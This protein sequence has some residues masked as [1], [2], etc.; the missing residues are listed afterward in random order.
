MAQQTYSSQGNQHQSSSQQYNGPNNLD[1]RNISYLSQGS[2]IPHFSQSP[3]PTFQGPQALAPAP[4]PAPV[5]TANNTFATNG[6]YEMPS[7][8]PSYEGV[9]P[10]KQQPSPSPYG[11]GMQTMMTSPSPATGGYN[12]YGQQP[13][14]GGQPAPIQPTSSS[15]ASGFAPMGGSG[16]NFTGYDLPDPST[17]QHSAPAPGMQPVAD[18][19]A[20]PF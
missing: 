7:P 14:G 10:P 1:S 13:Y 3:Q 4:A 19:Y 15:G 11:Q 12:N 20:S 16:E 2:Q 17:F 5:P 18:P 9:A 6:G 8:K